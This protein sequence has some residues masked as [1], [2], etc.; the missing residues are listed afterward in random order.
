M[1]TDAAGN[2]VW[3]WDNSDPFGNNVPN[4]NPSGIGTFENP[5]RFPGQYADKETNTYYNTNRNYDP[6]IGRYVE[7]DPI[8]LRGGINTYAYVKGNPLRWRDP[9]GLWTFQIGVSVSYTLGIFGGVGPSGNLFAG[10]TFDSE[11]NFGTYSGSGY[12]I[13]AGAGLS[14]G[15]SVQGSNAKTICDL[16]DKFDNISAGGGWGPS[17]TG[18]GFYG[19]SPNGRVEGGGLT[20]GPGLGA[21]GSATI[22][23]TTVTVLGQVP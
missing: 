21:T 12:G 17:A 8:G 4:E 11:G 16:R 19:D 23:D 22:T 6:S 15:I 5:L 1:I 14:G 18:D 9:L 20:I 13:G 7:S 2:L 3:A 10:L